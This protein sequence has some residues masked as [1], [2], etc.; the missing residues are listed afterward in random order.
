MEP[1][2]KDYIKWPNEH[3]MIN[4]LCG[5]MKVKY[6]FFWR[7]IC[8]KHSVVITYLKKSIWGH[9]SC[10]V[11]IIQFRYDLLLLSDI[12]I[13]KGPLGGLWLSSTCILFIKENKCKE[14]ID[15]NF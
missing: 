2:L 10:I 1:S 6:E 13:N 15:D 7:P 11:V 3:S 9:L 4:D 14:D 12:Y 5:M 8:H